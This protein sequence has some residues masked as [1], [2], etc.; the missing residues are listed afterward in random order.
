M[1]STWRCALGFATDREPSETRLEP[2]ET[3]LLEQLTAFVNRETSLGVVLLD[4]LVSRNA[5]PAS[6]LAIGSLDQALDHNGG[7][8][9]STIRPRGRLPA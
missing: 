6:K 8:S 9:H 2:F 1:I 5:P 4:T 3:K 7:A